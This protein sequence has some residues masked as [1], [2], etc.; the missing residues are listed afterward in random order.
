MKIIEARR[1]QHKLIAEKLLE[2]ETFGSKA[3]KSLL[4]KGVMPEGAE[5][6]DFP[7]EKEAQTFEEAKRALEEKDAEKQAEE[8]HEF[9]EAKKEFGMMRIN[10]LQRMNKMIQMIKIDKESSC[11]ESRSS[12]CV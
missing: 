9:D 6:A 7:S 12:F 5:S 3:I 4:E 10:R 1:A 8:K 2:F 11:D